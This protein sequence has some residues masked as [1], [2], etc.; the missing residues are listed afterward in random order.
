MKGRGLIEWLIANGEAKT[1]DDAVQIGQLLIDAKQ[2]ICLNVEGSFKDGIFLAFSLKFLDKSV[3]YRFKVN[4]N[5]WL[6]LTT[7]RQIN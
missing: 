2:L 3:F 7:N 5:I 1:H 6:L 4:I